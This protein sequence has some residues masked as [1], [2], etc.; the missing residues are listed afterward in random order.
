VRVIIA[1]SRDASPAE[2]RRALELCPWAPLISVVVSGTAAGADQE[3]ERWAE[4]RGL[5][6]NRY[7][8]DWKTFGRR[9]GPLRNKQ[10][11]ENAEGLVAVWDGTS[12]GTL[13]MIDEARERGLRVF[14]YR[15][16]APNLSE[17]LPPKG[18]FAEIW[19][20]AMREN[21][22]P[23]PQPAISPSVLP[24]KP[25]QQY[26]D[27]SRPEGPRKQHRPA[28]RRGTSHFRLNTVLAS[29]PGD[30]SIVVG[31]QPYQDQDQLKALRERLR[32]THLV[33]RKQQHIECVAYDAEHEVVGE[34]T[35]VNLSNRPDLVQ[36]L[37]LEWLAR[38]LAKHK[39]RRGRGGVIRYTSGRAESNLLSECMPS[40][41]HLPMGVGQRIAADFDV[42]RILGASGQPR[43]VIA[44][45]IRTRIT[46][47]TPLSELMSLG[48]DPKGLYV[49]HEV[50]T[51]QGPELRLAGRVQS[52]EGDTLFL[53]DH[54]PELLSLPSSKAW[55]E[56]RK[57]N[58]ERVVRAVAG[59]RAPQIINQLQARTAEKLGGKARL[60]LID[61]WISA[62]G[63][64]PADIA[65][66][67]VVRLDTRVLSAD[68]GR[69][70]AHEVL[71]RPDLVFDVS[72]TKTSQWNQGGLDKHGP[73]NF[74]RFTPKRLNIAIICQAARQGDVERFIHQLLD[75]IPG[76]KFA[77]KGF[78]RLYHLE[79]PITRTFT[80]R[81]ASVEHYREAVAAAIDDSTSR[82]EKWNLA[83][84]QID[85]SFHSLKGNENPYLVTKALFLTQQTPSQAFEW[86]SIKPGTWLDGTINNISLAAY[87]KVDGIPWLL[88][89]QQ[90]VSHE[91]VIGIGSYEASESRLGG[92]EKYIGVTTV[93]SADGRYM[94]ESRTPAT[95]ASDYLPALLDALE[96]AINEVRRQYAW[97]QEEPVRLI[98]H[99]FKDFNS[100]EIEAVR[101]L[102]RKLNLPHAEF[103]FVH[104]VLDHPYMLF[105]PTEEGENVG[106]SRRKGVASAP[107]GLR[108]DLSR[109]EVLL[110]MKGPKELRQW[111][112]GLPKPLLLRL[113]HES[114]F[115]DLSYLAR[116]VF[117]FTFLSWRTLLPTSLP[118]SI[119]YSD[120]VACKLLELRDVSIWIPETILGPVGR[121]RWF[122]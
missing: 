17:D 119:K 71:K 80:C 19:E 55:L 6:V 51:S 63:R 27:S 12:R 38:S 115:K 26:K 107:R 73:Y 70:P 122:L 100:S 44:I 75:G 37:L 14:V 28:P 50:A 32:E 114:T 52:I 49:R 2:V 42:R 16:D 111:S 101:R 91:L 77:D 86:E 40:G 24:S 46:I 108:V 22:A 56:P 88:P 58:L 97:I 90:S 45:D 62:L 43:F 66:G 99:I 89:V 61:E 104:V 92:R 83:F 65:Q 7:P 96:R 54:P 31:R 21:P 113:H 112:D 13:N 11:S 8:A 4:E 29:L 35:T 117:D 20:T 81:S 67:I 84:V 69:F 103:A 106:S 5:P 109:D 60:A 72:R 47:D 64:F 87:A 10:M 78:I 9:A 33:K 57:E 48:L 53:E 41:V 36:R 120:L 30:A 93:F 76:S 118:I 82:N 34:G 79:R 121:T 18:H 59:S 110:C 25:N 116:Q 3:G 15:A 98:F 39:P 85:E 74:E 23:A 68:R 95:P 102:M 105:D 94:L 1:G